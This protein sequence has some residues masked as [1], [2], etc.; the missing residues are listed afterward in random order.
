[1]KVTSDIKNDLLTRTKFIENIEIV[2]KKKKR[3]NGS[4]SLVKH[5]PF[6]VR[7][8][9]DSEKKNTEMIIDFD[10]AVQINLNFFDGTVK[11]YQD[12]IE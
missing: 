1:M 8:L 9:E 2:S 11:T 7:I 12:E 4:L 5:D 3:Y 6:E 10:R